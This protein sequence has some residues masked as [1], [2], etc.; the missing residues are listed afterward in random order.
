MYSDKR[1]GLVRPGSV[2]DPDLTPRKTLDPGLAGAVALSILLHAVALWLLTHA[3]LFQYSGPV[4]AQPIHLFELAL[5]E[6]ASVAPATVENTVTTEPAPISPTEPEIEPPEVA[7]ESPDKEIEPLEAEDDASPAREPMTARISVEQL[8]SQLLKTLEAAE[9]AP[10]PDFQVGPAGASSNGE[11]NQLLS[12]PGIPGMPD[13][14]GW[15]NEYV[16]PVRPSIERWADPGG[17]VNARTVL[18]NGQVICTQGAAP[19]LDGPFSIGW[20]PVA[21][22]RLCGR[23]RPTPVDT[24]RLNT[25]PMIRPSRPGS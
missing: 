18:S 4:T 23:E 8:R 11:P 25:P 3:A 17:A 22:S 19:A 12:R 21:M 1:P 6:S 24:T 13:A 14:A 7:R 20:P 10:S 16:G 15:L 5:I 2:F 9:S